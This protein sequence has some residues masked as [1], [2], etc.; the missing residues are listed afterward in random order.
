MRSCQYVRL[1]D[2]ERSLDFVLRCGQ[3][4]CSR[5]AVEAISLSV[6]SISVRSIR[7]YVS[8]EW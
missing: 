4:T 2:R 8:I 1:N 6:I 5:H 7:G 3:Y